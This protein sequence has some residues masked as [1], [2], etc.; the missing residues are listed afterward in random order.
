MPE[1][2][3][4]I[5]RAAVNWSSNNKQYKDAWKAEKKWNKETTHDW[6]AFK[7]FWKQEVHQWQ[8][9]SKDHAE[10]ANQAQ[11]DKLTERMNQM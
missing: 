6:D 5:Q 10:H 7:I 9:V 1:S 11:V 2:L 3:V 8:T 4:G